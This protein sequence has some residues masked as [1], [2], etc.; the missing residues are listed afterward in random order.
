LTTYR[1][2]DTPEHELVRIFTDPSI[3]LHA[4]IAVHST[5]LGAAA[6]GC[7][8]WHYDSEALALKDALRLSKGMSY[9]NAMAEL[10]FG[11]GKSVVLKPKTFDREKLFMAFGEAVETLH[12]QYMT[13]EDVGTNVADMRSVA[14]Q[15]KFVGGISGGDPSPWTAKGV[16]LAMEKA[17]GLHLGSRSFKT[18]TVAVQGVGNVG[19]HLC[20]LI[21]QHGGNL[22]VAD[23]NPDHL[24][25]ATREFH[26]KAVPVDEIHAAPCDVFAPCALGAT[27]NEHTIP[28]IK[29]SV[30]CGGANNQLGADADGLALRARGIFYVPDYVANAGGIV[31]VVNEKLGKTMSDVEGELFK[32]PDRISKIYDSSNSKN[33]P[34]NEIA[35]DMAAEL[36]RSAKRRASVALLD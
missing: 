8:L 33:R 35:D 17:I 19:R 12:G 36:I 26:A 27:L 20:A 5:A 10:P 30:V 4:I 23:V 18:L 7:R 22:I 25:F 29:A 1:T 32:I 24:S 9:K 28:E 2:I 21:A 16:Y 34:T 13:A 31:Q 3:G 15:T 14:K 11:G 6:G